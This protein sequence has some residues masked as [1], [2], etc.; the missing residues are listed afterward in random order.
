M[1]AVLTV[2]VAFFF[3]DPDRRCPNEE[4]ALLAPADGKIVA[5][6]SLSHHSFIDGEAIKVSIFLSIFD[7][8]INR[9]PAGGIVNYVKYIPGKFFAAFHDKA[10]ELNERTE[11]GMTVG[12]GRKLVVKQ[13]AGVL[14]RRVVCR[15]QENSV[16]KAGDRFGMIRFGSRTDLIIPADSELTVEMGDH[17]TGGETVVGYLSAGTER[18]GI[19]EQTQSTD[20]E[21]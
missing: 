16:V 14:A 10:S 21:L 5:I 6:D 9:I 2:F 3:R 1:M 20:V 19:S 12:F 17:V 11:I 13:I 8:H 4:N 7:V 15:L 18:T